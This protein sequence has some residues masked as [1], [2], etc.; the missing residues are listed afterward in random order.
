MADGQK[1]Y[2]GPFSSHLLWALLSA[3]RSDV[4]TIGHFQ[5][6][7]YNNSS[8]YLQCVQPWRWL[9]TG[10]SQNS[11]CRISRPSNGDP[12]R[13]VGSQPVPPCGVGNQSVYPKKLYRPRRLSVK[14]RRGWRTVGQA[15]QT[16]GMVT[17]GC[18]SDMVS[19]FHLIS[20][21]SFQSR[22]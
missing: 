19:D 9:Y 3:R 16:A 18:R 12:D 11:Q 13:K 21:F 6:G 1:G 10:I 7:G 8:L 4:Q 20:G 17:K 5:G 15:S 14:I 22:G 2:R